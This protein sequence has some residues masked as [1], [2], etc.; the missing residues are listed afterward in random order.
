[1]QTTTEKKDGTRVIIHTSANTMTEL[2]NAWKCLSSKAQ[3][4]APAAVF[5]FSCPDM[6]ITFSDLM[7]YRFDLIIDLIL[8]FFFIV[9]EQVPS[10]AECRVEF[11]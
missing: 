7:K 9:Q 5:S 10:S 6:Q 8:I 11:Q 3:Q 4:S 1:M 2:L